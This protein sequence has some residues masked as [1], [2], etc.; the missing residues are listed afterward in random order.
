MAV[1]E[2]SRHRMY[3]RLEEVMGHEEATTLMDHLPPLGWPDL[4]TKRD[5]GDLAA[6]SKRDIG[7]LAATTKRDIGELRNDMQQGFTDVRAEMQQGVEQERHEFDLLRG[8]TAAGLLQ[9]Q[10]A[11][12]HLGENLATMEERI[13][14]QTQVE[15]GKLLGVFRREL[16]ILVSGLLMVALAGAF[17]LIAVAIRAQ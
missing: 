11:F 17:G 7:E 2:E 9:V 13:R 5:I 16:V 14:L 12:E 10:T 15:A 4:A 1:T 8:A 6:T 3:Q